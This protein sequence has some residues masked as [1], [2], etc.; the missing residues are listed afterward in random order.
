M[1][2]GRFLAA[3]CVIVA[4]LQQRLE[5]GAHLSVL[6]QVLPY[7]LTAAE[8]L[9]LTTGLEFAFREAAAEMKSLIMSFWLLTVTAGNFW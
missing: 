9:V 4:V 1:S 5:G 7:V 2:Y 8:V 3:A 6:W